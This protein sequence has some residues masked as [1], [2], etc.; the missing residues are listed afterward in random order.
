MQQIWKDDQILKNATGVNNILSEFKKPVKL[1][2]ADKKELISEFKTQKEAALFLG[3]T[4]AHLNR[5]IKYKSNIKP[6]SNKL[7]LRVAC[8]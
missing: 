4:Q 2:N 8:R 6:K 7:G 5:A 1:Y 3:V